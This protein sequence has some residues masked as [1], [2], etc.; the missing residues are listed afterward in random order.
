MVIV[1][2]HICIKLHFSEIERIGLDK[3]VHILNLYIA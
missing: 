2:I 3:G 1:V